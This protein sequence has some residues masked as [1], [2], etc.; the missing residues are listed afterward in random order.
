MPPALPGTP[1]TDWA[2]CLAQDEDGVWWAYEAVPNRSTTAGMRTRWDWT[3]RHLSTPLKIKESH[4]ACAPLVHLLPG[5][6]LT[7]EYVELY[8]GLP[9]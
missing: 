2:R 6:K 5:H 8:E 7:R 9:G 1:I 4:E 3:P